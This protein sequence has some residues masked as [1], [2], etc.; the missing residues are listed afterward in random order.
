MISLPTRHA[1]EDGTSLIEFT[2]VALILLVPMVFVV[3]AVFE[4]QAAAYGVTAATRAG[5]RAYTLAPNDATG[6]DRARE[7]A[8]QAMTDQ[9]WSLN[10]SRVN[11]QG[12]GCFGGCLEP[13]S[14]A[15]LTISANVPLPFLPDWMTGGANLAIPVSSTHRTPYGEYRQGR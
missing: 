4:V 15:E 1:R 11:Y 13:G 10:D 12:I 14:S 7:A 6:R 5:T 3:T 8:E 2:W 9:G